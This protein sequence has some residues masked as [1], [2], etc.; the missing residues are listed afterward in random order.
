[1]QCYVI[2]YPVQSSRLMHD[3]DAEFVWDYEFSSH[4]FLDESM[5]NDDE[6]YYVRSDN[7]YEELAYKHYA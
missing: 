2:I 6:D 5:Q 4:D 3:Y 7:N 1:M